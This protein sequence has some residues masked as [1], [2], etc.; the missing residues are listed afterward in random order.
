MIGPWEKIS[1]RDSM[2]VRYHYPKQE[3]GRLP[4]KT[5]IDL[6]RRGDE[7][8]EDADNF[9]SEAVDALNELAALKR[10]DV[11]RGYHRMDRAIDFI[12]SGRGLK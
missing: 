1:D 5:V 10:A 8:D 11:A 3:E 12:T 6:P 9:L 2:K 7:G 4:Y